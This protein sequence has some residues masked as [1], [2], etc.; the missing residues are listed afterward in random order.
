MNEVVVSFKVESENGR[1]EFTVQVKNWNA[2]LEVM[3]EEDCCKFTSKTV[4]SILEK[5]DDEVLIETALSYYNGRIT[6]KEAA[7][8][9]E[10]FP[11]SEK[12]QFGLVAY[13]A[14][15]HKLN[16]LRMINPLNDMIK[17]EVT[18]ILNNR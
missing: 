7:A 4:K 11:K 5:C 18:D 10:R 8:L 14:V 2:L 3:F 13:A 1:Q 6:V 16:I 15:N 12:V 17:K 9:M